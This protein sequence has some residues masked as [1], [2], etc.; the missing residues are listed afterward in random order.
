MVSTL[1]NRFL[2]IGAFCLL[3]ASLSLVHAADWMVINTDDDEPGSLRWAVDQALS[4]P[5]ENRVIF[6]ASLAGEYIDLTSGPLDIMGSDKLTVTAEGLSDSV[7]ISAF[8][9]SSRIFQIKPGASLELVNLSLE[10]GQA[11]HG[12]NGVS[13]G[14]P[15]DGDQ[16][17]D[18]GA[19]YNEGKLVIRNCV[20]EGNYAG[21]G[22]KGGDTVLGATAGSGR[23]GG[24]G[25][26]GAI[27]STGA[28]A[29]LR[30][31]NSVIRQNY[32]GEGGN[33]GN[34]VGDSSGFVASGGAGGAGGAIWCDGGTLEILS[35]SIESNQAGKGGTGGA[36][37][38]DQ[39]IGGQGGLGGHGGGVAISDASITLTDTTVKS[40]QAGSGGQG[41]E[42]LTNPTDTRGAGGAGG[43]GGGLFVDR[44]HASASAQVVRSLFSNNWAGNGWTGGTAPENLNNGQGQSGGAGGKGGALYV[45]GNSGAV[46]RMENSTVT[47]NRAGSGAVG[48][49]GAMGG[50][51]GGDAGNGGGLAFDQGPSDYQVVLTHMTIVSNNAGSFGSGGDGGV[52]A[53]SNG[54]ASSGGGVWEAAG[55]GPSPAITLANSV[56]ALNGADMLANI[57]A[58][59]VEGAS[60]T[61]GDPK[62][63]PLADNGGLTL[64]MRPLTGSPLIDAG[65]VLTSPMVVDQRGRSRIG[66][67]SADLGSVE[68]SRQQDIR[69]GLTSAQ[70]AHRGNNVYRT[71]GAGQTLNLKLDAMKLGRFYLSVQNDGEIPDNL[72]LRGTK[73]NTTMVA[74][75]FR[76]TGGSSNV[77]GKVFG[78]GYMASSVAP[79]G[80]VVFRVDVKAR[81][82]KVRVRNQNLAFRVTS[83]VS[84]PPDMAMVKVSQKPVKK[85]PPKKKPAKK[86]NA[87]KQPPKKQPAKKQPAKKK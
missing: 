64:T 6:D 24:G 44:F 12:F 62:L 55:I 13:S 2:R 29:S 36:N 80:V 63:G 32:A 18:G 1:F 7:R 51:V 31:E 49:D 69:I 54:A 47:A 42:D 86:K 85:A 67:R 20:L 10:D 82:K 17:Q 11:P 25:R 81:S 50:G 65:K 21:D 58:F 72:L 23:G 70:A 59:A 19:I 56:V 57:G 83:S 61:S 74:S 15:T 75:A 38:N 37:S 9:S 35:S 76:V 39:G 33:G 73:A 40:N 60:F 34:L 3:A 68:V 46:W 87:K 79:G 30:I 41:G 71:T 4:T 16:G 5:G 14:T 52:P 43:N 8:L 48:G 84:N 26:G 78:N 66:Q 45:I 22:G 28:G 27:C 77:S 53:A